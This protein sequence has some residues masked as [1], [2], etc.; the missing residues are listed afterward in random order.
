MFTL[1]R[2]VVLVAAA[3]VAACIARP[4]SVR[5]ASRTDEI[6]VKAENS[7]ADRLERPDEALRSPQA[8]AHADGA[9]GAEPDGQADTAAGPTEHVLEWHGSFDGDVRSLPYEPPERVERPEHDLPLREPM[10]LPGTTEVPEDPSLTAPGPAAN[11]A[12]SAT[13]N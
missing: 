2:L 3:S 6:T 1:K 8:L 12:P 5:H 4:F 9:A 7:E 11:I 10:L 13:A